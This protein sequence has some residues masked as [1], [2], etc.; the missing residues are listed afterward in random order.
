MPRLA[1]NRHA[2]VRAGAQEHDGR[3]RKRRVEVKLAPH[4]YPHQSPFVRV[5]SNARFHD[6]GDTIGT[7]PCSKRVA[8]D[9]GGH[10]AVTF[11]SFNIINIDASPSR[12]IGPGSKTTD[13]PSAI[14]HDA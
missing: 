14:R 3:H 8:Q 5:R 11:T 10:I 2:A 7:S 6:R 9:D 13:R 1:V 12:V 4:P